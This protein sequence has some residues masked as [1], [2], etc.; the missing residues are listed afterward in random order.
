MY[1]YTYRQMPPMALIRDFCND[2]TEETQLLKVLRIE[3]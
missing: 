2:G 3:S 1:V